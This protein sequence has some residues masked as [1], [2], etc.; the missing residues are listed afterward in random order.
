MEQDTGESDKS[1]DEDTE[2]SGS[3]EDSSGQL[4]ICLLRSSF[5]L[6]QHITSSST[7]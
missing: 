2:S 4:I 6:F 5:V 7:M 1:S 3:E